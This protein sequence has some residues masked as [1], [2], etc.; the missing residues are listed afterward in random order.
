M[1]EKTKMNQEE[2]F[3]LR[4]KWRKLCYKRKI[5]KGKKLSKG[6]LDNVSSEFHSQ[7]PPKKENWQ[8]R[9]KKTEK[10]GEVLK[11]MFGKNNKGGEDD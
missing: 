3:K 1:L 8:P 4:E 6:D 7:K 9:T 5:G 11:N 10:I 2:R